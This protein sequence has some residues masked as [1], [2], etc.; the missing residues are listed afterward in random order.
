MSDQTPI[1]TLLFS[2]LYPSSVRP[3]HGI[4]VETR[5]K[6]LLS[7]GRIQTKVVAPVP[8]FFSTHPRYGSYARLASTPRRELHNGIDVQHP[9]YF[10]LPKVGMNITPFALAKGAAPAVQRL[11]DE[12][13]DFDVIDAHYY[14]PDGVAAAL[15]ARRFSKP[16]TVTARGS[17][18]NL[19]AT[20]AIPRRLMRWASHRASGSI[21]VSRALSRAMTKIGMPSSRLV[22]MPNGVDLKLFHIQPQAAARAT[23]HWPAQP[24]LL[25]VGNLVESKGH[26]VA[27]EALC[28]LPG[29]HLVIAGVGPDR[30]ALECLANRLQVMPRVRFLGWVNQQQLADCYAA[31]DILVL[32]SSREGWPNVLL[33]SMACGTPVVATN[34]G[35]VPEIVTSP[36][37]GRLLAERS[38]D[39]VVTTVTE[40]WQNLP[41]R[42]E[43]FSHAERAGW[44]STTDAQVSLF[45]RIKARAPEAA[46]A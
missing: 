12:G 5:L 44:Q 11:L 41:S 15:L 22:M 35:G 2:T 30:E 4:F 28:R 34:V 23:L 37:A 21:A 17:D 8:W 1:R 13:F 14:Y 32:L 33:E 10:L 16:F 25:S 3:G 43:V 7:S 40:L 29:F 45:S 39:N 42:S 31:A 26:H 38:V 19:I 46:H 36:S 27:I 24:T 18:I 6:E 9:R 20:Y